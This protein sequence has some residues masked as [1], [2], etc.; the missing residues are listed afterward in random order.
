MVGGL[1]GKTTV[2]AML[3]CLVLL[4]GPRWAAADDPD[5]SF[6]GDDLPA[7]APVKDAFDPLEPLNRVFFVF[8]DKLY[9]WAIKP[10]A[11]TYGKVV[12]RDVRGCIR[13]L[14]SNLLTP[15]R[16][17]N[18]L[19]QGK[20]K[21]AGTELARFG[22]NSTVGVLGLADAA[23]DKF[24]LPAQEEDFGQTLGYYGVGDKLYFCWPFFGPSNARDSVGTIGD[25]FL[26]PL[27]YLSYSDST[28]GLYVQ[29]GQRVNQT[30]LVLGDYEQFLES[31]FD[32]YVAM[33]EAYLQN[34]Q[35]KI[36]DRG[37]EN[38]KKW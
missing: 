34:R 16:L 6:L 3:L 5:D 10:V 19:L 32:P 22:I 37:R 33:R 4:A 23:K 27:G 29:G 15:V 28:A 38:E 9:F 17:V 35:A 18:C 31:S 21:A 25:I 14:F 11:K 20:V 24:D 7:S 13:N 1:R 30:S 36:D 2:A 26:S 12:P 8:N